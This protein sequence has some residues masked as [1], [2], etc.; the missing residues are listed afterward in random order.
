MAAEPN[1]S[2]KTEIEHLL[3][4]L[5]RSGCEFN[6]NGRWYSAAEARA[7]IAKKYAYLL[8]K[9]WV[10]T[11]EEFIARAATESSVSGKP[12][13]V[14]CGGAATVPSGQWM[15]EELKRYRGR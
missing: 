10:S 11:A 14:R 12:Y 13:Q 1:A 15:Q 4:Y 7:H 8:D 3:D 9:G 5:G 6:R 2:A